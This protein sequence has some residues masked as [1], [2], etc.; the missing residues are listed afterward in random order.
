MGEYN[1]ISRVTVAYLDQIR[2][3]QDI[4]LSPKEV[5]RFVPLKFEAV[6]RYMEILDAVHRGQAVEVRPRYYSADVVKDY[7]DKHGL[8]FRRKDNAPEQIMMPTLG[9]VKIASYEDQL[10]QAVRDLTAAAR[11]LTEVIRQNDEIHHAG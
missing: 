4:G 11:E 9:S 1:R 6:R 5:V 10:L 2:A 7:C 3:L 8:A